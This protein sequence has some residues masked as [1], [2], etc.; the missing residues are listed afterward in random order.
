VSRTDTDDIEAAWDAV[1][2]ALSAG[3]AVA[4]PTFHVEAQVRPLYDLP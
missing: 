3:W 4:S 1:F 2:D